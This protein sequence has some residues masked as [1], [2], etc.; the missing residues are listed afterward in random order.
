MLLKAGD[1][2]GNRLATLQP[3]YVWYKL[4]IRTEIEIFR[5]K[6]AIPREST[7]HVKKCIH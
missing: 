6:V 2:A 5:L 4:E 1:K 7:V 3:T